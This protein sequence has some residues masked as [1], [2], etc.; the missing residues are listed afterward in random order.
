MD[1]LYTVALV[2]QVQVFKALFGRLGRQLVVAIDVLLHQV[3]N[4]R[5]D[6]EL[7]RSKL[8][9]ALEN[10]HFSSVDF[11]GIVGQTL[12]N[13]F[14]VLAR[15]RRGVLLQLRRDVRQL[16]KTQIL[17]ELAPTDEAEARKLIEFT[18]TENLYL[19][20]LGWC[21]LLG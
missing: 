6:R 14:T 2:E 10:L 13:R 4:K 11:V 20:A 3:A 18:F 16:F 5:L 9:D 8:A 15:Q 1:A 21:L 19:V 7:H 12:W 17:E